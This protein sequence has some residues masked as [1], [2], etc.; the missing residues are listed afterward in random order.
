M[1]LSPLQTPLRLL[2]ALSRAGLG[3][4]SAACGRTPHRRAEQ[5]SP[6]PALEALLEHMRF[7][8]DPL[9]DETVR[10][11]FASGVGMDRVNELLAHLIRRA[12]P[13]GELLP[14]THVQ[15]ARA[16]LEPYLAH[17]QTLP[18][19]ADRAVIGRAGALF[20]E[21]GM[22]AFS[23]L[24]CA[25]LP[26]GYAAP[27]AARV[28]GFT[29][30]LTAHAQR[31]LAETALFLIDVMS[32][33]GLEPGG[34][35]LQDIARVRLMHAAIRHL[36]LQPA[37]GPQGE[38]GR[39]FARVLAEASWDVREH[40]QPIHQV[41]MSA[42]ILC[43][44]FVALRS[45]RHLGLHPP[46][47]AEH[48][49]LHAWNVVGHLMGVRDELLLPRPETYAAAE[50]LFNHIWHRFRARA[51]YAEGTRLTAALLR[52]LEDPLHDLPP[53]LPHLPRLVMRDLIGP[54][55]TRLLGVELGFW[56]EVLLGVAVRGIREL[57]HLGDAVYERLPQP[58]LAAEFLFRRL[59][60]ALEGAPRGGERPPFQIPDHLAERWRVR[61]A[62]PAA[63]RADS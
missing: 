24:G 50:K 8:A 58:R 7:E 16:A 44:S 27:E 15:A 37:P 42:T 41:V 55:L 40:G 52:F 49:Y 38:G 1:N 10:Q 25:S 6:D 45:V 35:G 54:D 43:F 47:E 53:P 11:L 29:Q 60:R 62:R 28:L 20:A 19:W 51:P 61:P 22:L 57:D 30:Q 12:P 14:G 34:R 13:P 32:L 63:A 31:R 36:L 39:D 9:A 3:R 26:V 56:D 4:L 21:H 23:V 46:P 33:G 48:A 17:C 2:A 5:F 18:P 59:V